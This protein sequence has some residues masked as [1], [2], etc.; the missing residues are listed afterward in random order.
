MRGYPIIKM[1]NRKKIKISV[2]AWD[3]AFRENMHT[4]KCMANQKYNN[5]LIEFEFLW[6]WSS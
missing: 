6:Q 2:I 1:F 3:A 5:K 4:I